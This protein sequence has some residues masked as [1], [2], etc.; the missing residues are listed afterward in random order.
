V[1]SALNYTDSMQAATP[2]HPRREGPLCPVEQARRLYDALK[3]DGKTVEIKIYPNEAH[4]VTDPA[5][6]WKYGNSCSPGSRDM[7]S[8]RDARRGTPAELAR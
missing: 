5:G 8:R 4:T 6:G 7:S 2:H 3:A 1:R